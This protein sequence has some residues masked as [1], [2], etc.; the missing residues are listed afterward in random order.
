MIGLLEAI[1]RH[2]GE[3]FAALTK[4]LFSFT[5]MSSTL[6]KVETWKCRRNRSDAG[7]DRRSFTA[8]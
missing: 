5:A 8:S 3:G 1:S 6:K 4:S 7:Q 2:S